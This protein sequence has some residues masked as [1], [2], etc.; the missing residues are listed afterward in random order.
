MAFAENSVVS[1]TIWVQSDFCKL[2]R[3]T[4]PKTGASLLEHSARI[5]YEDF[6]IFSH[7]SL[8]DV[9]KSFLRSSPVA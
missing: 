9:P 6:S 2:W 7:L 4:F 8:S 1:M 3:V 5:C